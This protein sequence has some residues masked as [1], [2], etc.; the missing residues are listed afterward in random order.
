MQENAQPLLMDKSGHRFFHDICCFFIWPLKTHL[1][2]QI[3]GIIF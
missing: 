1:L 2:K 3:S